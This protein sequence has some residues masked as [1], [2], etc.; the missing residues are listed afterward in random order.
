MKQIKYYQIVENLLKQPLHYRTFV[1]FFTHYRQILDHA[2]IVDIVD[3]LRKRSLIYEKYMFGNLFPKNAEEIGG[4]EELYIKPKDIEGEIFWISLQIRLYKDEIK[5]FIS[6]KQ[7]FENYFLHG[8]YNESL[9]VLQNIK[10]TLGVSVWYYES[11]LLVYEYM[12][13]SDEKYRLI[14]KINSL[15]GEKHAG[16][17]T[18]LLHF[19]SYRATRNLSAYKYDLDL[20]IIYQRNRTEF[21]KYNCDY[22]LFRLNFFKHYNIDNLNAIFTFET[23]NSLI[24]RYLVLINMFQALYTK[25]DKD[26][27]I[28][29]RAENLYRKTKD[30]IWIPL[31]VHEKP[32]LIPESYYDKEYITIMDNYYKGNYDTVV[33]LA[34]EYINNKPSSFDVIVFYC[35]SLISIEKRYQ[36]IAPCNSPINQIAQKVYAV[37]CRNNDNKDVLYNLYQINKNLYSFHLSYGLDYFIKD[38]ENNE[39]SLRLKKSSLIVYDPIMIAD[40]NKQKS[41]FYLDTGF[42]MFGNLTILRQYRRRVMHEETPLGEV[43]SYIRDVDNAKILFED[44]KY[45]DSMDKWLAILDHYIKSKPT[46]QTAIKYVFDCMV[47]DQKYLAAVKFYV[48]HYIENS[49]DVT[50]VNIG[51]FLKILRKNKYCNIRRCIEL[52]IFIGLN[53]QDDAGFILQSFCRVYKKQLPSDLFENLKEENPAKIECFYRVIYK[54]DTL[55]HYIFVNSTLDNLREQQR[56]LKYLVDMNTSKRP[57]YQEQL[58]IVSNGLIVYEGSKKLDESK[59]FVNDQAI[60]NNELKDVDGLFNRFKTIYRLI[61]KEKIALVFLKEN[62]YKIVAL[63]ANKEDSGIQFSN[64]ALYEVFFSIFD[65]IRDKFL[66]SKYGIVAYLSTRIRHGVLEGELRPEIEKENL[67]FN[68]TNGTYV[69]NDYW[70]RRYGIDKFMNDVIN[71]ELIRF[72]EVIDNILYRLIKERLQIKDTELHSDGLFNYDISDKDLEDWILECANVK[73]YQECCWVI[74]RKLWGR[75]DE[76]LC[77]IR[78]YV[79]T[80]IRREFELSFNDLRNSLLTRISQDDFPDIYNFINTASTVID[81]KVS[82]IV[83]WFKI[84]GTE[85]EDFELRSL[86]DLVWENTSKCYP[87]KPAELKV[88]CVDHLV[89]K[90]VF[91]IHF[92]DVFRIYLDNMFKYGYAKDNKALEMKISCKMFQPGILRCVF[93][94]NVSGAQKAIVENDI[95]NSMGETA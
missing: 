46:A 86:L 81:Q 89:I 94:N 83:N 52:P 29:Y 16:F 95:E 58:D 43:S 13:K 48:D 10:K 74:L 2:L 84:S 30:P 22:F 11:K 47:K 45:S 57:E 69:S 80:E 5:Y 36:H 76:N 20:E 70:F 41:L 78:N 44:G 1:E 53:A 73:T 55:R 39:K 71:Q 40:C 8:R 59:I 35:R 9:E 72:S 33:L 90:G 68:K 62:S 87:K 37:L 6:Q 23:T 42:K 54:G 19:I 32:S 67:V 25:G 56:I 60:V 85:I 34:K 82:K 12:D 49:D 66:N 38:E 63:D 65:L 28:G 77:V 88:E 79:T 17:V 14:S 26:S 31:F 61:V 93:Q 21:Q 64:N 50:K 18:S 24:D 27:Y 91:L 92:T 4:F 51:E 15:Q 3:S 7:L 75:T